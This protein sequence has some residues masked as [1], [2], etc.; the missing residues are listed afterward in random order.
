LPA[1]TAR[2][3][4]D[5]GDTMTLWAGYRN[6]I[7]LDRLCCALAIPSPKAEGI[8]GSQILDLWLTDKVDSIRRYNLKFRPLATAIA[9]T[10]LCFF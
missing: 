3:G 8:D 9:A 2:V 6:T 10:S 5:Y 4:K 7:G 1:P